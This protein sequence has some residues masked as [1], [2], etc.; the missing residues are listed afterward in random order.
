MSCHA[1][2]I[3]VPPCQPLMTEISTVSPS[4]TLKLNRSVSSGLS[5]ASTTGTA[6][7]SGTSSHA[8]LAV[9]RSNR[10]LYAPVSPAWVAA[11]PRPYGLPDAD[12]G[13]HEKFGSDGPKLPHGPGTGCP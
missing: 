8:A 6:Q 4:A 9:R 10:T 1:G 2:V 7:V 11:T 12:N 5:V 3:T 13:P